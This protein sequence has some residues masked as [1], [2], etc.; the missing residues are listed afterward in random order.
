MGSEFK[1]DADQ[2]GVDERLDGVDQQ[3]PLSY[4]DLSQRAIRSL[5]FHLL[6]AAEA[7]DYDTSFESI[8]ENFNEGFELDI[9]RH[10]KVFNIAHQIITL[11]E[12][13]DDFYKPLLTN[14][15]FDRIGVATKL[16]LRFAVWELQFTDTDARIVINEAVEL[17]KCFAEKDAF[18]FINGI[19]DKAAKKLG[20]EPEPLQD[21]P[22]EN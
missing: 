19:L 20:K 7:F 8:V 5:I 12:E 14:W 11:R 9:P 4:E 13:L 22:E 16:I 2:Q 6:Y 21:E 17:A 18:R 10:S 1:K 3:E 15:R